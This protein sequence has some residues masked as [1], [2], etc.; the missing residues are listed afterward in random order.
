MRAVATLAIVL[1]SLACSQLQVAQADPWVY[2]DFDDGMVSTDRWILFPG[3][4]AD[5]STITEHDG[6][7]ELLIPASV[8][9]GDPAV[10]VGSGVKAACLL[11]G[12]F[13]I[14]VQFFLLDW[15][16]SSGVRLGMG[17]NPE[18]A[19]AAGIMERV[20][21]HPIEC[22]IGSCEHYVTHMVGGLTITATSDVAGTLRL[23]RVGTTLQG[24]YRDGE[25]WVPVGSDV[26][27]TQDLEFLLWVWGHCDI[28][29]NQRILVAL[30]N[31]QINSGTGCDAPISVDRTTW[32]RVKVLFR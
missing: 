4:P 27:P 10:Q 22:P 14:Q 30:D 28:F 32:G 12:D 31:M 6:R 21:F 11:S 16:P 9:T 25:T 3:D 17:V 8:C 1:V 13:D 7:L 15:P 19:G 26:C 24:F 2:D 23:T 20:S 18:G 29:C 5:P